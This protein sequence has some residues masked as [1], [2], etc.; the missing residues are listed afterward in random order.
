[1]LSFHPA[2]P[3]RPRGERVF[4][5]ARAMAAKPRG[6]GA[7]T[8]VGA[9]CATSGGRTAVS[10]A[11]FHSKAVTTLPALPQAAIAPV[12]PEPWAAPVL[13][14]AAHENHGSDTG[15]GSY[16][17]GGSSD[18]VD[19]RMNPGYV[20]S[21]LH[22]SGDDE[23]ALR[24]A[25]SSASGCGSPGARSPR[26]F[27][28]GTP[29]GYN[30]ASRCVKDVRTR[31]SRLVGHGRSS[32][33]H[34]SADTAARG[35]QPCSP[36]R[37]LRQQRTS[38]SGSKQ[39]NGAPCAVNLSPQCCS[40]WIVPLA[41]FVAGIVATSFVANEVTTGM[42]DTNEQ[43]PWSSFVR[44]NV[45]GAVDRSVSNLELWARYVRSNI[46]WLPSA[47]LADPAMKIDGWLNKALLETGGSIDSLVFARHVQKSNVEFVYENLDR[48]YGRSV[49][50][51]HSAAEQ[52][53]SAIVTH[54]VPRES[55]TTLVGEDTFASAHMKMP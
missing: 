12:A 55:S 24:R 14:D 33:S 31:A 15:S 52:N 47:E 21:P 54:A 38:S 53:T 36:A 43:G 2:R 19:V 1:M 4:R 45:Y 17:F 37:K 27:A 9:R 20:R 50:I 32:S 48:R 46:M 34:R 39:G 44:Q 49:P 16:F 41:A 8:A 13:R 26:F 10:A 22:A 28:V 42:A 5:G 23:S 25:A 11:P 30:P 40:T 7:G 35:P 18:S 29:D 3:I 6:G 51:P